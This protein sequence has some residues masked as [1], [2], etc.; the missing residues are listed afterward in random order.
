[1]TAI[2]PEQSRFKSKGGFKRLADAF[3]YSVQGFTAALRHEASFRQELAV[4][5]VLF[6]LVLWLPFS[7]QERVLLIGSILLVLIVELLNSAIEAIA[8]RISVD[9][10][11]LAGRAKDLGSAAVMLTLVLAA[12][13]WLSIAGPVVIGRF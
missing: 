11:P 8:D 12:I 3:S 5:L 7:A 9:S 4:A 6:P 2:P 10:H 1:M 13:T